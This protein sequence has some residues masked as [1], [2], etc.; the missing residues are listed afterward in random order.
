M[1][2][3]APRGPI[4]ATLAGNLV[5]SLPQAAQYVMQFKKEKVGLGFGPAT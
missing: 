2:A 1:V 4:P 3:S 5:Q